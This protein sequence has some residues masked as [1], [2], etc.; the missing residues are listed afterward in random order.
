M[1]AVAISA[2]LVGN[3]VPVGA[4]PPA[5]DNVISVIGSN[6][7]AG[8][9][10]LANANITSLEKTIYN[11]LVVRKTPVSIT[12]N[13]VDA[14]LAEV[15]QRL[16]DLK[17]EYRALSQALEAAQKL[18]HRAGQQAILDIGGE[19]VSKLQLIRGGV[20]AP[21]SAG[22]SHNAQVIAGDF[23]SL[24]S[25]NAA[26]KYLSALRGTLIPAVRDAQRDRAH[27]NDLKAKMDGVIAK[28]ISKGLVIGWAAPAAPVPS[29][30]A[31]TLLNVSSIAAVSNGPKAPTILTLS[32]AAYI[33]SIMTYHYFNHGTGP[34]TI[35]LKAAD[36][37]MYGPWRASGSA[38]QGGVENAYWTARPKSTIPAGTYTVVD[39]DPS[40]WSWAGDTGG[41]GISL[42]KGIP[43]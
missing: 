28:Y 29:G 26:V 16:Q 9:W 21:I 17:A 38:G 6:V 18:S 20:L 42:I 8:K 10:S 14:R 11:E 15:K 24:R 3:A 25:A 1:A 2:L 27:L 40:T 36:G 37:T 19:L 32:T 5:V 22:N 7:Q 4:S 35:G 23:A 13:P 31:T 41:A 12:S 33:T 30:S 43:Q 34:G 39:S